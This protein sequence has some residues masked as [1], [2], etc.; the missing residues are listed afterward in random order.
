[1]KPLSPLLL[2]QARHG[3]RVSGIFGYFIEFSLRQANDFTILDIYE[4]L[5][6]KN[7]I[8]KR[9]LAVSLGGTND[10]G[11]EF[12][13][14]V[15]ERLRSKIQAS[16]LPLILENDLQ[17]NVSERERVFFGSSETSIKAFINTGGSYA[18]MGS[19]TLILRVKPGLT[20]T[21]A[22]PDKK[23]RGMIFSMID[24]GIPVI[25]LL[26]LQGLVGRYKLR[27]DPV[28]YNIAQDSNNNT[29][30]YPGLSLATSLLFLIGFTILLY[31]LHRLK[32]IY[33]SFP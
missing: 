24:K 9:P 31:Y 18:N 6:S 19:S 22:M 17:S 30:P 15:K 27:W 11:Q 10:T 23:S 4:L 21:I 3:D 12:E 32:N 26:N 28:D 33:E 7:V 1:M 13:E 5:F 8:G 29:T 14:G 2:P 20:G 25:H 16:D